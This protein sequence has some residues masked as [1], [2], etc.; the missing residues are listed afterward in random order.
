MTRKKLNPATMEPTPRDLIMT[1]SHFNPQLAA[2]RALDCAAHLVFV[3]SHPLPSFV[4]ICVYS[5]FSLP[6]FPI[7]PLKPLR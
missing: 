5:W 4:C 1:F 3:R 2:A 7:A 6:A